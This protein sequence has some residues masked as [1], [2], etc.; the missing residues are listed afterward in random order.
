MNSRKSRK[1]PLTNNTDKKKKIL[2]KAFLL[3]EKP[4]QNAINE[5]EDN[6]NTI[7]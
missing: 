7:F 5:A 1:H 3:M 4:W 6:Y 2:I